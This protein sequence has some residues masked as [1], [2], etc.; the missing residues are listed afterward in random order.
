MELQVGLKAL[1]QFKK[2]VEEEKIQRSDKILS[3]KELL[4]IITVLA[5]LCFMPNII[6]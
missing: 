3:L 1:A 6:N 2:N 4:A 5:V